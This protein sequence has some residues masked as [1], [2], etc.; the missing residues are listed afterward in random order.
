VG[1]T[2]ADTP[3]KPANIPAAAIWS[4]GAD[5]G[6]YVVISKK[7]GDAPDFYQG[8]IYHDR[9]GDLLYTGP[10]QINDI[11]RP[12]VNLMDPASYAGWDGT[13]LYL[14]DGRYLQ[15]LEIPE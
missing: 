9:T 2:A 4:G 1:D 15:A 11:N 14:S 10:L 12:M 6:V 7:E 13:H 5:G 3:P 8:K